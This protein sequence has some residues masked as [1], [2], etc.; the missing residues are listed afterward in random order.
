MKNKNKIFFIIISIICTYPLNSYSNILLD[1]NKLVI[2]HLSDGRM[3][4]KLEDLK[5]ASAIEVIPKTINIDMI[6]ELNTYLCQVYELCINFESCQYPEQFLKNINELKTLKS[7]KILNYKHKIF[8]NIFYKIDNIEKLSIDKCDNIEKIPKTIGKL[9][10]LQELN[11]DAN[12]LSYFPIQVCKLVH[13][14]KLSI[15]SEKLLALPREINRLTNIEILTISNFKKLHINFSPQSLKRL[16]LVSINNI[17]KL[18]L[19]NIF[20]KFYK[21]PQLM[22]C[23]IN[24]NV[25]SIPNN[26]KIMRKLKSLYLNNNN[27][28]LLN[29]NLFQL[30]ELKELFLDNNFIQSIDCRII[31]LRQLEC[32]SY[33]NNPISEIP[34]CL[35]N[36]KTLRDLYFNNTEIRKLPNW[37]FTLENLKSLYLYKTLIKP[38]EIS[39]IKLHTNII[40]YSTKE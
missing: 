32:L 28:K 24:S 18:S 17:N 19:K 40:R 2:K 31:N 36:M 39:D 6:A 5:T 12:S 1:T 10:Y 37:I 4:S 21:V 29:P 20:N 38:S 13:I 33:S 8:P 11:I 34:I 30:K 26:I 14:N 16:N 35:Q 7:L 9:K 15:S 25:N 23:I 27:I 3:I 22:L